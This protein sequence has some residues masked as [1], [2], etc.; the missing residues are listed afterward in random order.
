VCEALGSIFSTAKLKRKIENIP[1]YKERKKT[2]NI[3][4]QRSSSCFALGS[5][6]FSN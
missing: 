6:Y 3:P 5:S 4:L 1:K 2:A